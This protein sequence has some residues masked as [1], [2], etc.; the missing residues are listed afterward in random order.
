[1]PDPDLLG[2]LPQGVGQGASLKARRIGSRLGAFS[3]LDEV[4]RIERTEIF[5]TRRRHG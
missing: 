5:S 1:M 2:R 3:K 4:E